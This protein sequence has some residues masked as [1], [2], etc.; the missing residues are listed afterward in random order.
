MT[1]TR[2]LRAG[3]LRT[4]SASTAWRGSSAF[5][6]A[7]EYGELLIS[8]GLDKAKA[9]NKIERRTQRGVVQFMLIAALILILT[10]LGAQRFIHRPFGQL[11]EAANRWRIGEFGQHVD[12][13]ELGSR[14]GRP[15]VQLHGQCAEAP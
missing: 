15:C 7:G 10:A 3:P 8:Y 5:G 2:P 9:F 11:V 12:I 1:T 13:P 14:K 6:A 4:S